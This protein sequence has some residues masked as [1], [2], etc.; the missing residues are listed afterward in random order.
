MLAEK[1]PGR[2]GS[3]MA[4]KENSFP[5]M[6]P[7][8]ERYLEILD[9]TDGNRVVTMIEY[10]SVSNKVDGQGRE[11]YLRKRN[12]CQAAGVNVVEIDLQRRGV[13]TTLGDPYLQEAGDPPDYHGSVWR[14]AV[15][16]TVECYPMRLRDPLPVI[17]IPLR[18]DD[19]DVAL[20]LQE[21]INLAY[22]RGRYEATA[23]RK[24]P[25]PAFSED[26]E[27]WIDSVLAGRP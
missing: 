14:A 2:Y 10:L 3:T 21:L 27:E 7:F 13:P 19:G 9:A 12:D 24:R 17:A 15:R 6:N 1:R 25:K 5:G 26:D 23:Y 18:P 11:L 8:L 4:A 22:R 20:D 16:E